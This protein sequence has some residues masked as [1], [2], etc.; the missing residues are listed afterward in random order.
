MPLQL[1]LLGASG[2]SKSWLVYA[3][4]RL[5]GDCIKCSALMGVAAFFVGR[6]TLYS[7]LR[8]PIKQGNKT[9]IF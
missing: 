2:T 1:V 9:R 4:M 8:I 5:L 7:L 6:L 3:L